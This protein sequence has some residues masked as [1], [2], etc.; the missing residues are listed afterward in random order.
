MARLK[1]RKTVVVLMLMLALVLGTAVVY[2]DEKLIDNFD[3]FTEATRRCNLMNGTNTDATSDVNVLGGTRG[4]LVRCYT[5]STNNSTSLLSDDLSG[6]LGFSQGSQVVSRGYITWDGDLDGATLTPDGL[7]AQS[8]CTA[9]SGEDLESNINFPNTAFHIGLISSD[10]GIPITI[11]Y[12]SGS[13]TAYSEATLN[14]PA[15][16]TN[17]FVSFVVPFS[18][19]T[20]IGGGADITNV[21]AVEIVF[22]GSSDQDADVTVDFVELSDVW[23][24]GDLPDVYGTL[25]ASNGARHRT[26]NGL[27]LASSVSGEIDTRGAVPEANADNYDDGV[28]RAAV[29]NGNNGGWANGN[30][31]DGNGGHFTITIAGGG[32]YPQVFMDFGDG[33]GGLTGI[34]TEVTLLNS[35]GN[36][37]T[38]P[39]AAGTYQVY[40]NIPAGSFAVSDQPMAA[41]VRLSS[42]GGLTATGPAADGEVEDYIYSFGP[43]AV[44]LQ[45]VT[46]NSSS[47]TTALILGSAL[48]LA[49]VSVGFVLYRRQGQAH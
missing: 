34:L 16:I 40:F 43:T 10:V 27:R 41:R 5:A 38:L 39:L 47:P 37:L 32:G 17:D 8:G 15:G 23:D 11:R 9:N 44:S 31:S 45:S 2:A 28:V 49:V 6:Y 29:P 30:V 42:A 1:N 7:C 33:A 18:S 12:Y 35:A 36:P 48:M 19:F 26:I 14:L 22:D 13:A 20:P 46:A 3:S 21:G 24:F 25:R 4:L